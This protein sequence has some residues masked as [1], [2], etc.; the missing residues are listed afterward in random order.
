[1]TPAEQ[2]LSIFA[3]AR[4]L[5]PGVQPTPGQLAQMRAIDMR[6]ATELFML[7][8]R[9]RS[10]GRPWSGPSPTEEAAM[11]RMLLDGLRDLLDEEG[12]RLLERSLVAEGGA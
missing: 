3:L 6:H 7:R 4:R 8:E 10:E 9:A 2:P 12:R 1:M 5:L 11:R